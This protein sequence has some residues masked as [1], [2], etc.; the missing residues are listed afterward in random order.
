MGI[1][2]EQ[3]DTWRAIVTPGGQL[4]KN[5]AAQPFPKREETSEQKYANLPQNAQFCAKSAVLDQ[6]CSFTQKCAVSRKNA[7]FFAQICSFTPKSSVYR[8]YAVL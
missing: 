3:E 7:Q 6:I 5:R 8:K 1:V 2:K 4:L